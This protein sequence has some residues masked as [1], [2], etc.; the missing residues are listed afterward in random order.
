MAYI[1][2]YGLDDYGSHSYGPYSYGLDGHGLCS[3]GLDSFALYS[4]GL[5]SNWPTQASWD[6]IAC[7]AGQQAF[8]THRY[9][10]WC[11]LHS[12]L[13]LLLRRRFMVAG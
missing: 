2:I 9:F 10:F 13:L 3:Y 12:Q 1:G 4:Y 5:Y 8:V 6:C 11:R 7:T